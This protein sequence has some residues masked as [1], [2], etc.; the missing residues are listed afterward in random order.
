MIQMEPPKIAEIM[1]AISDDFSL[2]LF[3]LVA[4]TNCNSH[5][6]KSKTKLTRKQYYSRLYRLTRCGLIK[7]RDN[8]YSLTTFGR[9]LFDAEATVEN[10]LS[11]FWRIKAIDSLEVVDGIPLDEHKRLIETLI[12]DQ[13]IKS[14]LAK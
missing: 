2:E 9:I 13:G 7:R 1:S 11:N 3:K 6:L 5:D 12:K 14:I 8:M 4:L 10:A